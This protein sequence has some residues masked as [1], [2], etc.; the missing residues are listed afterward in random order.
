MQFGFGYAVYVNYDGRKILF[1]TGAN[2]ET[3][4]NNLQQAQISIS[5]LDAAVISHRHPDHIGGL[6]RVRDVY[7]QIKIYAPPDQSIGTGNIQRVTDHVQLSQ[8]LFVIRT[9]TDIPTVGIGDELS[10]LINTKEGSY[11]ITACSHTGVATIVDKASAIIGRDIFYY[12]GGARLKFRDAADTQT[13]TEALKTRNVKHVSPGH[14]SIDDA[15]ERTMQKQ[16]PAGYVK[17]RLG[18]KI[19]L[20][21]PDS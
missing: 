10:L 5:E 3:L 18:L 13:V 14:C 20:V 17:S 6:P 4:L 2:G 21:L 11:L 15:V 9:H 19:P 16:F 12:T 1:D 8:N 7:P